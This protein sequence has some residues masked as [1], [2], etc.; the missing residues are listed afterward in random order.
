[1][2]YGQRVAT[3]DQFVNILKNSSEGGFR[4]APTAD[5]ISGLMEGV[6][7][8]LR[9]DEMS[10]DYGETIAKDPMGHYVPR[11]RVHATILF[12]YGTYLVDVADA[13]WFD[14]PPIDQWQAALPVI[15]LPSEVIEKILEEE[16]EAAAE[17]EDG[18]EAGVREPRPDDTPDDSADEAVPVGTS[19][20]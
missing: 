15:H 18:G 5:Q 7:V 13:D 4:H 17:D 14:L 6:T 20:E 10:V 19:V 2:S 1:M 12:D 16:S 3:Y 11:H 9:L 8:V